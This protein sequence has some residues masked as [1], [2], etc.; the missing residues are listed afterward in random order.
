MTEQ[1]ESLT[2]DILSGHE[3]RSGD[4]SALREEIAEL[5]ARH[6][7]WVEENRASVEALRAEVEEL[8]DRNRAWIEDNKGA[9]EAL[10]DEVQDMLKDVRT[11]L[12]GARQ[13]WQGMVEAR[14]RQRAGRSP[15]VKEAAKGE[16]PA[17]T[18]GRARRARS[19]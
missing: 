4:L 10:K 7:T 13:A 3:E 8:R 19:K 2:A 17:R 12:E 15:R 16:P 11:D 5:R 1:M 18:R 9:V 14:E 6:Q